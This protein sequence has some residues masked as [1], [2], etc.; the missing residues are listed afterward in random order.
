MKKIVDKTIWIDHHISAILAWQN[1]ELCDLENKL[2]TFPG[3]EDSFKQ[4]HF[5]PQPKLS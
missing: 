5:R 4:F 2:P 1:I 3:N